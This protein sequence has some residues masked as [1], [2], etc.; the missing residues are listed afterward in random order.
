MQCAELIDP[1]GWIESTKC[2]EHEPNFSMKFMGEITTVKI[3][4][5]SESFVS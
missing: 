4:C 1:R 5:K 3:S 2:V